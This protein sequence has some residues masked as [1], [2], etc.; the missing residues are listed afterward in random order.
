[1]FEERSTNSFACLLTSVL[2]ALFCKVYYLSLWAL[3]WSSAKLP[4]LFLFCTMVSDSFRS[5]AWSM[6]QVHDWLGTSNPANLLWYHHL[7]LPTIAVAAWVHLE[8]C[9]THKEWGLL[10]SLRSVGEVWFPLSLGRSTLVAISLYPPYVAF[11]Q[12]LFII[13]DGVCQWSAIV[14]RCWAVYGQCC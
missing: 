6:T 9:P 13:H 12:E 4:L 5:C 3:C 11:L 1:M 2:S 10:I 7:H 8:S 14:P